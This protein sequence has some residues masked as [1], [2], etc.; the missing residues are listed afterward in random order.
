MN[1]VDAN[2][3]SAVPPAVPP[4]VPLVVRHNAAAQRFEATVDGQLCE[5]CYEMVDGVM[6]IVHTAVPPRLQGQGIAA[7]V[8]A[9]ALDHARANRLKVQPSCSYVRAYMRRHP[10]TQDLLARA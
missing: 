10:E 7:R 6:W 9:A 4:V 3:P 5:A 2:A 1:P 8:V